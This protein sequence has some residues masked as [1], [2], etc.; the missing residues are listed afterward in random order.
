MSRQSASSIRVSYSVLLLSG[1]AIKSVFF[2]SSFAQAVNNVAVCLLFLG[3]LKEV[4]FKI[5]HT[6]VRY[7]SSV[8]V[9]SSKPGFHKR[10]IHS[11]SR[12]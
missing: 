8:P 2:L 3:K 10:R 11:R 9:S 6:E 5:K 1:D 7:L 12:N 4:S